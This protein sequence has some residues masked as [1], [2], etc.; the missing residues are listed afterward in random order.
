M[1]LNALDRL[2]KKEKLVKHGMSYRHPVERYERK[3]GD[4]LT[5][6]LELRSKEIE[7]EEPEGA[8]VDFIEASYII[9]K[10]TQKIKNKL[11]ETCGNIDCV[12]VVHG[13]TDKKLLEKGLHKVIRVP[14]SALTEREFY[15]SLG[16][17]N[18]ALGFPNY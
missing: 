6:I 15:D 7:L 18:N 14:I 3:Q 17:L 13:L 2:L 9:P 16:K 4:K 1:A 12:Y 8:Y 5:G 11:E 10:V